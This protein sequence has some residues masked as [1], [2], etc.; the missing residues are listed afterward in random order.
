MTTNLHV[1]N[2]AA[3][4]APRSTVD[5]RTIHDQHCNMCRAAALRAARTPTVDRCN[6]RDR[7]YAGL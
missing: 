6:S 7:D 3:L 5:A 4:Y 2:V 1:L